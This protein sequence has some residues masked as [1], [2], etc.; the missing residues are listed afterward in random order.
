VLKRLPA[1]ARNKVVVLEAAALEASRWAW[2]DLFRED[3]GI[4]ECSATA[5]ANAGALAN[6]EPAP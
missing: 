1:V 5:S 3:G 2:P 4:L 6:D